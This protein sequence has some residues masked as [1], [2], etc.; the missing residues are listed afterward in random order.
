[1]SL[2]VVIPSKMA[3]NLVPCL[4]AV[5]KHEP[6]AR[7]IVV[8][9][10]MDFSWLPRPDLMPCEFHP[11][12][13]PFV[14]SRNINVGIRA[15][16]SDDVVLLNDDALLQTPG[17][18]TL[19]QQAARDNPEYGVIAASSNGVGNVRQNRQGSGLRAEP[20]MVC[21]VAVLVPRRTIDAV[22]LLDERY[23]AYGFDD[24]DYCLQVRRAGLVI[25]I[26]DGCFV[27]HESLRSTFRGGAHGH[28][29]LE[30]GMRIFIKKW[31]AHPL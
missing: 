21:F 9:D 6:A 29:S 22:G 13:N 15:A 19:L 12:V 31:G 20:R 10:G 1:V 24:D 7:L 5:R 8:D 30:P 16:G 25:G 23:T 27:D 11:G 14:F 2:S 4:E 26:H 17:G 18:F 3:S 28:A